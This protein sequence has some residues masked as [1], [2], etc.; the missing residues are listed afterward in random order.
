MK[1][2]DF[3]VPLQKKLQCKKNCNA[4]TTAMQQQLQYNKN[5]NANIIVFWSSRKFSDNPPLT[6]PNLAKPKLK[7]PKL[8][9]K[10]PELFA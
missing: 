10:R 2:N 4:K 9:L 5:C 7:K 8:K 1:N 6:S 3:G